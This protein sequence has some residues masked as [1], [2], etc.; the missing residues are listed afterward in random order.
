MWN[1]NMSSNDED[2]RDFHGKS[3]S[4]ASCDQ[5]RDDVK[6]IEIDTACSY[7]DPDTE[8][9]RLHHQYY[10]NQQQKFYSSFG[11]PMTPPFK[12]KNISASPRCKKEYKSHHD[13]S[14]Y[15]ADQPNYM[16]ATAS[17]K[18]R[19]RSQSAP[20]QIPMTPERE[21]VRATKKRLS[22]PGQ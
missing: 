13:N 20:R 19:E 15:A 4:R 6:N 21:K 14:F 5:P 7:S 2:L 16:T 3:I 17:A 10:H 12:M 9:W 8:F 18:A 11:L 22:F 1:S